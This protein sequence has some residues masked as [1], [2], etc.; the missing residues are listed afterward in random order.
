M[1]W[2]PDIP[3]IY[4]DMPR[5]EYESADA[6]RQTVL[7][8]GRNGSMLAI[9]YADELESKPSAAMA[10]GTLVHTL[11]LEPDTFADRYAVAPKVDR[12][13]KA[14]KT[15]WSE[16][17]A[18]SADKILIDEQDAAKAKACA[19]L[20]HQTDHASELLAGCQYE[21]PAIFQLSDMWCKA[22]LDAY[23]PG[24]RIV[25]LKTARDASPHGF[26]RA[27]AQYGYHIQAAW[28]QDAV[29]QCTGEVLPFYVIAL[30]TSDRPEVG[31]Y[32]LDDDAV[33]AGRREYQEL[34]ANYAACKRLNSW[35]SYTT[36]TTTMS[37][38]AWAAN[39]EPETVEVF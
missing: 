27:V 32:M 14:G 29:I 30:E 34:L 28:Y 13:T 11:V 1:T 37:L 15:Q 12:R 18:E 26:Q 35:P 20:V 22:L 38:P 36:K 9:K 3:G 6:V 33:E 19:D 25:D 5:G 16:F 7:K 4:P 2:T 17:Q 8:A 31:V 24:A 21:C 39:N 23:L 10:F